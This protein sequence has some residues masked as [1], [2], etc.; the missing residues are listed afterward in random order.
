[1]FYEKKVSKD[2]INEIPRMKGKN[3]NIILELI[4]EVAK[5]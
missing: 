4:A 1:M 5:K 3:C 2:E